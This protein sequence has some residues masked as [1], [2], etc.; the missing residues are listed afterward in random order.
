MSHVSSAVFVLKFLIQHIIE[1]H[2]S[3]WRRDESAGITNF[4]RRSAVSFEPQSCLQA[5][6]LLLCV[7]L[8]KSSYWS[9]SHCNC[10]LKF[11]L[12]RGI[13][14]AATLVGKWWKYMYDNTVWLIQCRSQALWLFSYYSS[15][16]IVRFVSFYIVLVTWLSD[17]CTHILSVMNLQKQSD[18]RYNQQGFRWIW[19]ILL[20]SFIFSINRIIMLLK[21]MLWKSFFLFASV[22]RSFC[23]ISA[24]RASAITDHVV[25]ILS[26]PS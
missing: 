7:C 17:C 18:K 25:L 5:S 14:H 23:V 3:D 16:I 6:L 4:Q 9:L 22:K 13:S 19:L 2:P 15:R 10:A 24:M 1:P 11:W 12:A 8:L 20:F 26:K 21:H